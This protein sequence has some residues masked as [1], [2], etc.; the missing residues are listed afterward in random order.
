MKTEISITDWM[1]IQNTLT[2]VK[3]WNECPPNA[4]FSMAGESPSIYTDGKDTY[5]SVSGSGF[6]VY[7][8]HDSEEK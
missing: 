1:K 8:K 7:Y 6:G 5:E 3:A 2:K 4:S